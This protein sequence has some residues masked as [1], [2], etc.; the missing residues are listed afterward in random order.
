MRKRRLS[1]VLTIMTILL[2][3]YAVFYTRLAG[4]TSWVGVTGTESKSII[5]ILKSS[6]VRSD[7]W[8]AVKGGVDAAAK[9][10]SVETVV[11]SPLV[12]TDADTQITLLD[13]AIKRKPHAIVVA[14]INDYR[15]ADK[16][17]QVRKAGIT[18]VLIDNPI[19]L[20]PPPVSVANDHL[21]AGRLAGATA[22]SMTGGHPKVAIISDNVDAS[23]SNARKSGIEQ[24]LLAYPDGIYGTY[25]CLD[26]KQRAYLIAKSLLGGGQPQ[27]NTFVTL[28]ESA[29]L[30]VAQAIEE[31]GMAGEMKLIGFESSIDEI[32][33]LESGVLGATLVQRPFNLGYLALKTALRDINGGD[34][35]T[36]TL[37]DSTIVNRMNMYSAENQKLLF[38]FSEK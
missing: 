7:F 38:P 31:A 2:V 22:I 4:V 18:L 13:E 33:L 15:M 25:Y 28:T 27:F 6:N 24:A 14:P 29:T 20:D 12:E 21:K 3:L 30:G 26:A 8:Q 16:L 10:L 19:P 1:L 37:I 36:T 9:E 17:E 35:E 32:Q 34:V 11:Q 5:V 23:A